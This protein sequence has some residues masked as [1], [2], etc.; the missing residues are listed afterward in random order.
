MTGQKEPVALGAL[1]QIGL[2]AVLTLLVAFNIVSLNGE[3]TAALYGIANVIVI[4]AVAIKTRSVVFAPYT[5]AANPNLPALPGTKPGAT[6]QGG[7]T[8]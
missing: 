5:V 6:P 8:Y 1:V 7:G 2:N 3:Q 4:V